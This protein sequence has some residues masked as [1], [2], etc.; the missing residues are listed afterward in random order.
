MI[1]D[2]LK[3]KDKVGFSLK[4]GNTKDKYCPKRKG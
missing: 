2:A 4:L 3:E 1:N